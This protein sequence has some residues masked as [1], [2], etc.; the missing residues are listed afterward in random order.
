MTIQKGSTVTKAFTVQYGT[1]RVPPGHDEHRRHLKEQKMSIQTHDQRNQ[2]QG[3][4]ESEVCGGEVMK[5]FPG[6]KR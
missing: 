2:R 1:Q 6:E 4:E 3:S 5:G